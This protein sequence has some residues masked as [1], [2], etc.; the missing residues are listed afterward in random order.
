[1]CPFWADEFSELMNPFNY[2]AWLHIV[3]PRYHII[4]STWGRLFKE[5]T[6]Q[7]RCSLV[8]VTCGSFGS[9]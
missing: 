9:G 3:L 8:V 2:P 5:L 4:V 6:G 1:M 7:F